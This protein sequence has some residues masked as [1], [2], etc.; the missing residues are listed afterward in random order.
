MIKA[1]VF[2]LGGVLV[3]NPTAGMRS[4]CAKLLGVAEEE[5]D[6]VTSECIPVFQKGLITEKEFWKRVM[7]QL[8]V[9]RS[10]KASIWKKALEQAYSPKEEMFSL[11]SGLKRK[12][13]KAG[14]LSNTELPVVEFL[15]DKDY[16]MFDIKVF[17]CLE[18]TRKPEKRIYQLVLERLGTRPEETVFIDDNKENVIAAEELGLIG[19]LF[20]DIKQ[21]NRELDRILT[22]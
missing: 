3:D 8:G 12:G 9:A 5:F 20:E 10:I 13:L 17:S 22:I 19:I 11:V 15:Q 14:L 21:I 1:V 4:Y 2:D 7:D 6:N 16:S 18:K